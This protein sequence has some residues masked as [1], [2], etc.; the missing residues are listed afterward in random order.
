MSSEF[1]T[2]ERVKILKD[3]WPRCCASEI[4]DMLGGGCTRN[5]VIGKAWR[6]KLTA[7]DRSEAIRLVWARLTPQERTLWSRNVHASHA[8]NVRAAKA[9]EPRLMSIDQCKVAI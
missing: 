7:K 3:E 2:D 8:E 1:W 4:A 9:K 5:M 6:L